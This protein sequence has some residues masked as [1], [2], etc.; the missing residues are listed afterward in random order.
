M[1]RCLGLG[2]VAVEEPPLPLCMG[3]VR[4]MGRLL[5]RESVWVVSQWRSGR[6][7]SSRTFRPGRQFIFWL[8]RQ[9]HV[10]AGDLGPVVVRFTDIH[11]DNSYGWVCIV[12]SD[13]R[14]YALQSTI[15]CC[16][17][18]VHCMSN[19]PRNRRIAGVD[20]QQSHAN[21]AFFDIWFKCW[22]G[23]FA[24]GQIPDVGF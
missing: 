6:G 16:V 17:V 1:M 7:G 15:W 9:C 20:G 12:A 14:F 2:A 13:L 11:T 3:C 19:K 22:A 4:L 23:P 8:V 18:L 5:T 24:G 21:C 10:C